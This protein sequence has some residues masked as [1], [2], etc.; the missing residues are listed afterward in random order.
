MVKVEC[1]LRKHQF[2]ELLMHFLF[3][4]SLI[5]YRP[6]FERFFFVSHHLDKKKLLRIKIL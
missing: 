3:I 1:E 5:D 4:V 2:M 6:S